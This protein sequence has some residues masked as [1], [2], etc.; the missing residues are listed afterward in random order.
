MHSL[1]H[2]RYVVSAGDFGADVAEQLAVMH[3]DQIA[4][5]HLTNISPLHAVFADR[6][7]LDQEAFCY[8]DTVAV[9]Q[10]KEGEYIA[11]QST[12]P[13]TVAPALGDSPAGLAAWLVE[14]LR[15]GR[16]FHSPRTIC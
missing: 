12:K 2:D 8:L 14:K 4:T 10:R 11:Q 7:T 3:P 6:S 13:H 1:G 16:I 15:A 9:W 5:L